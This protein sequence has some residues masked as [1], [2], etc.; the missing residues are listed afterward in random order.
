M[1]RPPRDIG[2]WMRHMER[3]VAKAKRSGQA[4][5]ARE[6]QAEIIKVRDDVNAAIDTRQPAAP[7]EFSIQ[8]SVLADPRP[9][10]QLSMNFSDVTVA[11]DASAI[12]V[13][14]Y[15][16]WGRDETGWNGT[17]TP[18]AYKR[19]ETS[20]KSEFL[21]EP[22]VP[23]SKWRFIVR[24][25]VDTMRLPGVWSAEQVVTMV[26]DTTPP[27]IPP[28]PDLSQ[29]LG[30]VTVK[31]DGKAADDSAMDPDFK[32]VEIAM[33]VS[34]PGDAD[35]IPDMFI[36]AGAIHILDLPYNEPRQFR[37]RA[38]DW[39]GNKSPWSGASSITRQPLVSADISGLDVTIGEQTERA[40]AAEAAALQAAE[41][42]VAAQT[43]AA[44]SASQAAASQTAANTAAANAAASQSAA[45]AAAADA[46]QVQA[47]ADATAADAAAAQAAAAQSAADA[48]AAEAAALQAASD[49]QTAQQQLEAQLGE[50]GRIIYGD[51]TPA[52]EDQ[53][54][55]NIWLKSD[56]SMWRWDESVQ[57]WTLIED[58]AM[59]ALGLQVDA[60]KD[61][62][63]AAE[64][65]A[66][67][68]ASEAAAA[69]QA[70]L[71]AQAE[72]DTA[73]ATAATA[74]GNAQA[75]Q[76]AASASAT[77]ANQA[78]A[79]AEAAE[80]A[81]AASAA[82]AQA[83]ENAS[84]QAA[85]D[86]GSSSAA[87]LA[88]EQA[89][90]AANLAADAARDEVNAYIL[91]G[92]TIIVNGNFDAPIT[93]PPLGWPSRTLTYN[94]ASTGTARSGSQVLR[95][96][97]TTATV[98]YAYTDWVAGQSDRT[99]YVEYYVRLREALKSGNSAQQLGVY[100]SWTQENGTTGSTSVYQNNGAAAVT[101]ASLSTTAWVKVATTYKVTTANVKLMRFGPRI[102][103]ITTTG[104]NF[105]IDDFRVVD[106][107]HAQAA[108]DA[109]AAA[110]T[111]ANTANA[112]AGAA[113]GTANSALSAATHNA[114]NLFSVDPPSGTAPL[115]TI[116]FEVDG[117]GKIENQWQ[118]TAGDA[119]TD[120]S[121][122]TKREVRSEVIAN[123]DVGKLVGGFIDSV[124]IET[125]TLAV[126]PG[127]TLGE[128]LDA[129]DA[130]ATKVGS[131]SAAS[132]VTFIDGG[133]VYTGSI[134]AL[135]IDVNNLAADTGF[136]G[137]MRTNV[138]T[139]DSVSTT[140][141]AA[142]AITSKHTITGAVFQTTTTANRGVKFDSS[143][144]NA[145]DP[146]G[147]SMFSV[148]SATGYARISGRY[149]SGAPGTGGVGIIPAVDSYNLAQVAILFSSNGNY[150]STNAGMW[151]DTTAGTQVLNLR[152]HNGGDVEIKSQNLQMNQSSGRIGNFSNWALGD[153]TTNGNNYLPNLKIA[154]P[155]TAYL[156][157]ANAPTSSAAAN[158]LIATNPEGVLYRS[159]SSLRYKADVQDWTPE[160]TV[161]QLS[162]RTWVDRQPL[163]SA[164][165]FQRYY[166][167]IA[168]EVFAILP[169]VVALNDFGEPD[170]IQY[171]RIAVAMI[172]VLQELMRR[173]E[174]LEGA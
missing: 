4:T 34:T 124:H 32:F 149:Y 99:Y 100:Y 105:E 131:W 12:T 156:R 70:A 48:A 106:I 54:A 77:A 111:T 57:D 80:Q 109:A 26:T 163:D 119:V 50:G 89:A 8:T 38:V 102:P 86:A 31:W 25:I 142:G 121:T 71:A 28:N 107:T 94:E 145:W 92:D 67:T 41:D 39:S 45:D 16:L 132:D 166:G 61:A 15:E 1:S 91:A 29:N 24:A 13:T 134:K 44:N 135:Q 49:A 118:Q 88:A 69:E 5:L 37:M 83:A 73:A 72:A 64:V 170:S 47:A 161:L 35:V 150:S 98:A 126:G 17:G 144:I 143:G 168:E 95:A 62:A 84:E 117:T 55:N 18:P 27:K 11:T 141:L 173:V 172:P 10:S 51:T 85:I 101:L 120:G 59:A 164:D 108:L 148:D 110:Q 152:G 162:P 9:Y 52:V 151:V 93:S 129:S 90:E 14:E 136:V 6:L 40:E 160:L 103:A 137:S 65:N 114:K 53:T 147:V 19:I 30:V 2:E 81:A 43:A 159:T 127:V 146:T 165:P 154:G 130:T 140:A 23:G 36:E 133:K 7:I 46:A 139:A 82:A 115:G 104:Q 123:L 169:E 66:A 157:L 153:T 96:T 60:A 138:L 87:A 42:A 125:R 68:S 174:A 58:E 155:S 33:A 74:Q 167:M 171:D 20:T 112:T 97:P 75:A 128:K 21:A 113:Q 79:E 122:W 78:Q 76:T 3:E 22:F 56:G 116:W 158:V 63:E